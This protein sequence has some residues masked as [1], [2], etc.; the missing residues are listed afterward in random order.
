[1]RAAREFVRYAAAGAI[2]T[3]AQYLT[4]VALVQ[5]AG[6]NAVL[7]STL[8]MIAGALINYHLNYRYTFR[9][10][11]PHREAMRIFFIVAALALAINFASM[12]VL[13]AVA[14]LHY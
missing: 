12:A 10:S 4:L 14:G 1:M 6:V 8:G 11:Q 13:T 7:T 2:G 3:V 5:V 9:S